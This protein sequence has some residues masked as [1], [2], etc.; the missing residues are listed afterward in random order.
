MIGGSDLATVRCG[1]LPPRSGP[2]GRTAYYPTCRLEDA[3]TWVPKAGIIGL[4][5]ADA[6]LERLHEPAAELLLVGLMP[7][8]AA[9][10]SFLII[11]AVSSR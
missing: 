11:L 4:H 7:R 9:R 2:S 3:M 10:A 6:G 8:G 1:P 5:Y